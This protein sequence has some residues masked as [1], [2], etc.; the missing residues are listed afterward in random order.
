MVIPAVMFLEMALDSMLT[1]IA[2]PAN[3]PP[4]SSEL[5]APKT[6]TLDREVHEF[7]MLGNRDDYLGNVK[8]YDGTPLSD[9]ERG[10]I[11]G[12]QV[13]RILLAGNIDAVKNKIQL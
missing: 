7:R 12:L 13:A 3:W 4:L 6:T 9:K 1:V 10:Y 11:I 5:N 2:E 8:T